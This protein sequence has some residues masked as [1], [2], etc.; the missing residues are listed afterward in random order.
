MYTL[1]LAIFYAKYHREV[2]EIFMLTFILDIM[3]GILI[4]LAISSA[5]SRGLPV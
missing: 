2:D 4:F 5:S 3:L 1:I